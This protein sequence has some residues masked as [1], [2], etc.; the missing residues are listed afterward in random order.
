MTFKE[1]EQSGKMY[2]NQNGIVFTPIESVNKINVSYTIDHETCLEQLKSKHDLE[3]I[4]K[5]P[6]KVNYLNLYK[7]SQ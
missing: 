4:Y 6:E 2:I 5:S 3:I 1:I 7:S